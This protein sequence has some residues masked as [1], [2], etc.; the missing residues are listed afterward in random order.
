MLNIPQ[1]FK[2]LVPISQLNWSTQQSWSQFLNSAGPISQQVLELDNQFK[3]IT[4]FKSTN[5]LNQSLAFNHPNFNYSNQSPAGALK[6]G[7]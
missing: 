2:M 5:H 1:S 3:S 4:D 6:Q 7:A